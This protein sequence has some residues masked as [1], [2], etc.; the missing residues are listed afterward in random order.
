MKT[1]IYSHQGGMNSATLNL[2]EGVRGIVHQVRLPLTQRCTR[3][4][5]AEILGG[6]LALGWSDRVPIRAKL[7]LTL[8]AINKSVGLCLQTGN[9]ARF[10]ADLLK[11]QVAFNDGNIKAAI[12]VLPTKLASKLMG[13]NLAS[14]ERMVQELSVFHTIITVPIVVIGFHE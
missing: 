14:Y 2:I 4:L 9:M 12:F 8:T 3:K 13:S 7:K 1:V 11:L 6:L 10:Y 5:R